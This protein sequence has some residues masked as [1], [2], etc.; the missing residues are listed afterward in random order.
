MAQQRILLQ[1]FLLNS[2]L[3]RVGR[4]NNHGSCKSPHSHGLDK[5]CIATS[6]FE[7]TGSQQLYL[8]STRQHLGRLK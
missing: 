4:D 6:R 1:R 5:G 7:D 3:C 8:E 2:R